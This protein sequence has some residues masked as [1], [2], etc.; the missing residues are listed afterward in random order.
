M[1]P[2][3]SS[4]DGPFVFVQG[5][6]QCSYDWREVNERNNHCNGERIFRGTSLCAKRCTAAI[7]SKKARA[8]DF[9][10]CSGASALGITTH[11]ARIDHLNELVPGND[12]WTCPQPHS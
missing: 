11:C 7:T 9:M 12:L 2:R 4:I 6:H 10:E 3:V 5:S 8:S 1:P